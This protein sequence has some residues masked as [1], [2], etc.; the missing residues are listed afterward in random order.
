LAKAEKRTNQIILKAETTSA[1][2]M[3]GEFLRRCFVSFPAVTQCPDVSSSGTVI[4]GRTG[5][6]KTANL[7]E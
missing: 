6:G 4:D 5:S 2:E 3:D 7:S 1:A